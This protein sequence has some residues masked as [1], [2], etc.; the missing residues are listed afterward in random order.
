MEPMQL[1]LGL[2][3]NPLDE[4]CPVAQE[5][6]HCSTV[7]VASY[8]R[9]ISASTSA[10]LKSCSVSISVDSK[11]AMTCMIGRVPMRCLRV[12]RHSRVNTYLLHHFSS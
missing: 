6:L 3:A 10:I 1:R 8:A 7:R 4:H 2:A 9:A 5:T 11:S 12:A